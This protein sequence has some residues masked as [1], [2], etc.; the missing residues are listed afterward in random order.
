[1]KNVAM[2]VAPYVNINGT[3]QTYVDNITYWPMEYR[4]SG[5]DG[6]HAHLAA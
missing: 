5:G 3:A 1:M 6:R 4:L 2:E